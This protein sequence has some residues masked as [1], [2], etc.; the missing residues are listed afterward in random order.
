MSEEETE[1]HEAELW[2]EPAPVE[3]KTWD[4]KLEGDEWINESLD[5]HPTDHPA[6]RFLGKEFL[7]WLWWRSEKDF[8]TVELGE[9]GKVDYWIDD[10]ISF[11]TPGED[12][13]TSDLKGGAP[14]TTAEAHMALRAGKVVETASLGFRVREREY[15][16]QFK[17]EGMELSGVKVPS[18]CDEGVD[19]QIFERMFLL[20]EITAILDQLFFRFCAQRLEDGWNTQVLPE[21]RQWVAGGA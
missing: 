6:S 18:E 11:R 12:P 7:L 5:L 19:E 15:V 9:M 8:G 10:R 4:Q 2:D 13:Q 20:D 14:A 16:L 21:I 17:G 1:A 3:D